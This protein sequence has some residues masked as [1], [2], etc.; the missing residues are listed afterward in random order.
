MRHRELALTGS[1]AFKP[2]LQE[3]ANSYKHSCPGAGFTIENQGS[4]DGL[5]KLDKAGKANTSGSPNMLAFSDGAKGDGYP[6]LLPRPI[7]F[8]LFTLVINKQAGVQDL[9][10]D[11]IRELYAGHITNWMGVGGNNQPVRLVS[12]DPDSGTRRTFQQRILGGTREPGSNSDDCEEVAPGALPGVVRCERKTTDEVTGTVART[13]GAIGYSDVGD[14]SGRDDLLLV[15][16]GGHQALLPEA[17]HGAYPFWETEYAYTYTEPRAD[18]LAASF[19]RYLTAEVGKDIVRS[20]G[21]RPC[22][23]LQN[24]VLCRPS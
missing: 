12:R 24:P 18:S 11:Q 4:G 9:S 5:R 16:I 8:S 2:V 10:L 7:A 14:A 17:D 13:S 21:S 15:R 3:A 6:Q 1:T 19:L 22:A 20:H 23:E